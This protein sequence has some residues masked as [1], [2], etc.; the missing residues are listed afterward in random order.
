[1]LYHIHGYRSTCSSGKALEAKKLGAE[2][3][4]YTN[5]D[6]ESGEVFNKI[7]KIKEEDIVIGSSLG[8]YLALCSKAKKK[9]LLNPLMDA[10]LLL[11]LGPYQKFV[12]LSKKGENQPKFTDE[13]YTF[14]GKKDSVLAHDFKRFKQ[15]S[16]ELYILDDDH[17]FRNRR[18]LLFKIISEIVAE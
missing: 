7:A 8:G 18:Q 14:L 10:S 2:C 5:E 1:M 4:E 11:L 12:E 17:N 3:I 16:K 13:I 6:I 15:I 9:I